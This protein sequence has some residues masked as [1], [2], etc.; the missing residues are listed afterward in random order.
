MGTKVGLTV[1]HDTRDAI[2]MTDKAARLSAPFLIS[3]PAGVRSV[4]SM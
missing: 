4:G 3:T 2:S 1:T